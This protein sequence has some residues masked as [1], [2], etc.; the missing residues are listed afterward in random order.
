M[1][2]KSILKKDFWHI[3]RYGTPAEQKFLIGNFK[4]TYD[5]LVINANS[6]AHTP[7][8]ISKFLSTKLHTKPYF[9]DPL[10]HAF[11]H[12]IDFILSSSKENP[13][14]IKSSIIKLIEQYGAPVDKV[15]DKR[16]PITH[17]D[18]KKK[19]TNFCQRVGDFQLKFLN[20]FSQKSDT[21]KYFTFLAS[22]GININSS[23]P[24][25]IV[26]PYFY[27]DKRS[28]THWLEINMLCFKET[29]RLF[30]DKKI[31]LQLVINKDLLFS[32]DAELL[33]KT[34]AG[35]PDK[36]DY[37][38]VWIDGNSEDELPES[39]LLQYV[40]FLNQL[41]NIAPVINL[42]GSF[43][44][45]VVGRNKIVKNLKGVAHGLEYAESR[46]VVP[47]GGGIPVSKYYFPNLFRRLHFRDAVAALQKLNCFTKKELYFEDI[48]NCKKCKEIITKSPEED[49]IKYGITQKKQVRGR[50]GLITREFPVSESKE[51]CVQHYMYSKQKEY[52]DSKFL[53]IS[54][55]CDDL[56]ETGNELSET[57]SP[58]FVSH[59]ESWKNVF[60][61]Y[62]S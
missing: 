52:E 38:L 33:S 43:F 14:Q 36:P 40:D 54:S 44:S 1:S 57:L 18:V 20:T 29:R 7:A 8:A 62:I 15:I 4:N 27:L 2:I 32:S 6:I 48:C 41:G 23:E 50:N 19:V 28:F 60:K 49:F 56:S 12:K 42:Y 9:I 46:E 22:K 30:S 47:V 59:C 11:Q 37:I 21:E 39:Y 34:I 35:L 3:V 16:E 10:T 45:V 26:S 25:F 61:K 55:I 53:D 17:Q 51:R 24:I 13:E 31:A 5:V 58:G